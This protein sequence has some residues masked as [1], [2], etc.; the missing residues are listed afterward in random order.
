MDIG[1]L[2]EYI[3]ENCY[4]E[5]IL[6]DIGCHS[7]LYHSQGY[8]TC[9]NSDGDNKQAITVYNNEWLG[10]INYTRNII[11]TDRKTDLIDLV[12]FNLDLEIPKA[13]KHISELIG[14]DYY[15][16]FDE[17]IPESL[18]I[19]KMLKDMQSHIENGEQD[20]PLKPISKNILSYYR[21]RVND[22]FFKDNISYVTQMEFEIGYDEPTNRITIPIYSEIGDLVG[23]K[24]R[25]FK[26][27]CLDGESKYI[28]LE[29]TPRFRI[30]YG[31]HKTMP[32][33]KRSQR[34][35]VLESEKGVMQLWE[36]GYQNCIG[37]GGKTLSNQQI[38]MLIRLGVEIIFCFDKDVE[39]DDY[40]EIAN[41]FI[42]GVSLYYIDDFNNKLNEKESPS[43]NLIKWEYLISN[44]IK[45][46]K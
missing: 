42:D 8:W 31:L 3:Y 14:L 37:I 36:Y 2:K 1:K 10:V 35:Y 21:N 13:L 7:I 29:P 39:F 22:L 12:C 33:I 41:R 4:I 45:K 30:L 24:G 15:H 32:Y 23:V 17:N 20:I 46:L 25:L 6:N 27:C 40:K 26:D 11:K 19:T 16:N 34:V 28:Y 43:D 18:Q 9:G 5:E 38:N 44:C